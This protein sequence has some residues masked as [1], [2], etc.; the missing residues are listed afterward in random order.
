MNADGSNPTRLTDTF[1]END[2]PAWSSDGTRIA[3]TSTRDGNYE[4]YSMNADGTSPTNLA[5]T[6]PN[7]AAAD[8]LPV[9]FKQSLVK[10]TGLPHLF[11]GG[12]ECPVHRWG[13]S[14]T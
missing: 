7:G 14:T 12:K 10:F 13:L 4:I 3:F 11:V 5:G 6:D 8:L 9:Q 1:G 2:S